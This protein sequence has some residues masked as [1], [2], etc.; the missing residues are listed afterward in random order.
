LIS[1]FALFFCVLGTCSGQVFLKLALINIEGELNFQILINPYLLIGIFI[2]ALSFLL[3]LFVL[4]ALPFTL[5]VSSMAINFAI[6]PIISQKLFG[7]PYNLLIVF[8]SLLIVAGVVLI[9]V[10]SNMD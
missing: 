5:A 6:I 1:Y 2:Y 4:Q 7:E 3:W 10:N 9:G 8:G